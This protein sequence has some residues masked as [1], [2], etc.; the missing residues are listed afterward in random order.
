M[1][2]HLSGCEYSND[3]EGIWWQKRKT[4]SELAVK[5]RMD[6]EMVREQDTS[7]AYVS[8]LEV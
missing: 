4:W 8:T 7:I 6:D 1:H 2:K 5:R 3:W